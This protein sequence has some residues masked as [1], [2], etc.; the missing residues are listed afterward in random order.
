VPADFVLAMPYLLT[1]LAMIFVSV[2]AK[3]KNRV[4]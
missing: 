2:W 1:L 4:M 3:R